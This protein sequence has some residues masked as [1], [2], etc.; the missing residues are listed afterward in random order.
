MLSRK[1]LAEGLGTLL[2]LSTIIGT[3]ILGDG[4]SAE[5][6]GMSLLPHA[7]FIGAMLFVLITLLGP[8]SGAHFNPAVTIVFALRG[9]LPAREALLYV[10]VQI[11]TAILGV[12]LSHL[13]F[14]L[15]VLQ[16]AETQRTGVGRWISEMVATFGLVFVIFAGLRVAPS[17]IP[18]LVGLYI[19]AA[20]WF[21]LSHS[22]ANPAVTI[23]RMFSDTY[24]GI[25]PVDVLPYILAQSA[26]ALLGWWATTVLYPSERN[27]T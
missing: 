10:I 14:D 13:M 9:D 4:L 15:S 7:M 16:I 8:V 11:P 25:Q 6:P 26:G 2:L 17:L 19:P 20:L 12:W 23:A 3:G 18:A 24:A 27:A 22:F 5:Q 21:T 1:L